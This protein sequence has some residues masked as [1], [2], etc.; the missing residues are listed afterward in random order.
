MYG[1]VNMIIKNKEKSES[2][3]LSGCYILEM[4]TGKKAEGHMALSNDALSGDYGNQTPYFLLSGAFIDNE[5][6]SGVAT[7]SRNHQRTSAEFSLPNLSFT[8]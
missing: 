2:A 5:S 7:E 3:F 6:L 1:K 8:R 4:N